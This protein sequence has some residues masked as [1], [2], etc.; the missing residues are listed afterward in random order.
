[1]AARH[2]HADEDCYIA[3]RQTYSTLSVDMLFDISTSQSQSA[4][5]RSHNGRQSVW[6]SYL[7]LAGTLHQA[8]N[9]PHRGG[10]QLVVSLKPETSLAGDY[11]T[12][13]KT[14][15]RIT[16]SGRHRHCFDA[17]A[18]ANGA[19]Y[20]GASPLKSAATKMR[21]WLSRT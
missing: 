11:W 13:R 6:W 15:G 16:T 9:P 5:I 12:E 3:V 14:K 8:G 20:N 2:T 1:V 7:S 4:D 10:A 18:N 19:D 17:Y 21:G